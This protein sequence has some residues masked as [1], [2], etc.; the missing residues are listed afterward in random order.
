MA[1]EN[2]GFHDPAKKAAIL[3]Q[4]SK[5]RADAPS[6][7]ESKF[8]QLVE[9]WRQETALLSNVHRIILHPAYQRIIGFGPDAIPLIL[10][11]LAHRPGHWFWALHSITGEDPAPSGATFKEAVDAWL[12]W[13]RAKGYI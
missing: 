2:P 5:G 10:R 6:E 1:T 13:G 11:E 12:N 8:A 7:L 3:E 9:R 4:G